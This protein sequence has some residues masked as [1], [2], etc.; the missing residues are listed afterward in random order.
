MDEFLV[1]FVLRGWE[2]FMHIFFNFSRKECIIAYYQPY[3]EAN[4]F[5]PHWEV[6]FLM[7]RWTKSEPI[8]AWRIHPNLHACGI[9][10]LVVFFLLLSSSQRNLLTY[11][12]HVHKFF[13]I[14]YYRL[15]NKSSSSSAP[16]P[17]S[18]SSPSRTAMACPVCT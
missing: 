2:K 13:F 12:L 4:F 6:C 8:L 5:Y 18:P 16:S 9:K 11:K 17:S 14:Q 1:S 7:I 10:A 3:T 15:L